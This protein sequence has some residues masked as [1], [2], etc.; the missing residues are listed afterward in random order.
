VHALQVLT[1]VFLEPLRG[2]CIDLKAECDESDASGE[3]P[4]FPECSPPDLA[5]IFSNIEQLVGFNKRFLADLEAAAATPSASGDEATAAVVEVFL[6]AAPFFKMFSVYVNNF[7]KA[8]TGLGKVRA[9]V[10]TNSFLRACEHQLVCNGHTLND[11][12]I[13]PIQRI[14]RYRWVLTAQQ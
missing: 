5:C 3:P 13:Q 14:P 9:R 12:L 8:R 4:S 1:E 10:R 7:E 2:W 6:K 11:F